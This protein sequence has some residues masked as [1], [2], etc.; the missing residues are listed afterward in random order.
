MQR[1]IWQG[2]DGVQFGLAHWVFLTVLL[3]AAL[4]G[5]VGCDVLM[6]VVGNE[7]LCTCCDCQRVVMLLHYL[8][9][10]GAKLCKQIIR[11]LFFIG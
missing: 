5:T 2:I 7:V 11:G 4:L 8:K 1:L 10:Q 6:P 3:M 9:L